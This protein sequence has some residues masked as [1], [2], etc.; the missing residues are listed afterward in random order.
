MLALCWTQPALAQT[1]QQGQ[2]YQVMS[3]TG[4]IVSS[5]GHIIT[6]HHVINGCKEVE[7]QGALPRT[8]AKVVAVDE[9][10]D[11][12][13]LKTQS[14]V[15]RIATIRHPDASRI[16][17]HEELLV[18]GYP[19]DSYVKGEYKVAESRVVGLKGPTDEPHWIQFADAAQQG[20]SGG[21]LLDASGNVAG[22]I[23]GKT[24]LYQRRGVNGRPQLV[25]K[26]DV[27]IA[28]PVLMRFL[29]KHYV[30]YRF[31]GSH[32]TMLSARVE[33]AAKAYIVNILCKQPT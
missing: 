29:D 18:M 28:L 24:E 15:R 25:S 16:R 32:S 10:Y 13:L 26:S 11:L 20:N 5:S 8:T 6:N 33:D 1:L 14:R 3:G 9:Q 12:A 17:M 21:P 2:S 7:L 23:V 31:R 22:V 27:A 19:L 30:A 4:F